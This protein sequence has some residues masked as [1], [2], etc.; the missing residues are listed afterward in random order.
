MP[1]RA[2]TLPAEPP[3]PPMLWARMASDRSPMVVT[4]APPPVP[5]QTP[6]EFVQLSTL[7]APP[8]PALP[9]EP[10]DSKKMPSPPPPPP[11]KPPTLCEKMPMASEPV[12]LTEPPLRTIWADPTVPVLPPLPPLPPK[13]PPEAAVPPPPLTLWATMPAELLPV[14]LTTHWPLT[15]TVPE[16]PPAPPEPPEPARAGRRAVAAAARPGWKRRWPDCCRPSG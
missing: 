2:P 9:P 7:A 10:P 14:V 5:V 15:S 4:D 13:T 12:V 1:T 8:A 16:P 6:D 3:P 11:A